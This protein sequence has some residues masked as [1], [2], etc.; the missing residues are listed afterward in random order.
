MT[1]SA[2]ND[3]TAKIIDQACTNGLKR[4]HS[5]P[6]EFA[7]FGDL[8]QLQQLRTEML[9]AGYNEDSSQSDDMLIVVR[10][11]RLTSIT[12]AP[13]RHRCKH[14]RRSIASPSMAGASMLASNSTSPP[15]YNDRPI[16]DD[17]RNVDA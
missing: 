9:A 11:R 5:Y 4:G 10:R 14:S 1:D 3:G 6:I 7:I 2:S 16:V 8:A 13:Q 12:S 17:D 15:R